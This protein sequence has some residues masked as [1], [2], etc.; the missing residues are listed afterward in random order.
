MSSPALLCHPLPPS[1]G[2]RVNS[3]STKPSELA[4]CTQT[5]RAS[6]LEPWLRG[7]LFPSAAAHKGLGQLSH[8][9]G[10]LTHAFA[11]RASSTV[12]PR[13]GVR[14]ILLSATANKGGQGYLSHSQDPRASSLVA[15]WGGEGHHPLTNFTSFQI[16][17][18]ASCPM[19]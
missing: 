16:N 17:D 3:P 2:G 6:C 15:R 12:L 19:F 5:S 13:P 18:R 10:W 9:L 1:A 8:P 11:I 7:Q 14:P 4:H